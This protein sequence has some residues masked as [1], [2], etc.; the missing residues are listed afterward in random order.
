MNPQAIN[1]E[2]ISRLLKSDLAQQAVMEIK[3]EQVEERRRMLAKIREIKASRLDLRSEIDEAKRKLLS[4]EKLLAHAN[5]RLASLQQQQSASNTSTRSRAQRLENELIS[6]APQE[7]NEFLGE[8]AQREEEI[9]KINI[10]TKKEKKSTIV[11][12]EVVYTFDPSL[13]RH[14]KN[15]YSNL[16]SMERAYAAI[17]DA[18]MEVKRLALTDC[19]DIADR[20]DELRNSIPVVEMEHIREG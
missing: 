8:L 16:P 11:D 5:Q 2:V 17:R 9:K 19:E 18:R 13:D 20:L 6:T 12:G 4:A 1:N 15:I 10:L 3:T 7:L 14:V